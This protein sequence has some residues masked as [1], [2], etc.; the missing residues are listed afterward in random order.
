[1]PFVAPLS[2]LEQDPPVSRR[3]AAPGRVVGVSSSNPTRPD[4]RLLLREAER[5]LA[6]VDTFRAEGCGPSWQSESGPA[7]AVGPWLE[8]SAI[9]TQ[10]IQR[11]Y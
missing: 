9:L 11:R 1:V 2:R 8:V 6:A 3:L 4:V 5:Y 7:G 10:S